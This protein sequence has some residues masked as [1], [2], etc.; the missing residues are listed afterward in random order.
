MQP[1]DDME[2]PVIEELIQRVTKLEVQL[3]TFNKQFISKVQQVIS[4]HTHLMSGEVHWQLPEEM[5]KKQVENLKE[6]LEEIKKK[7]V[8][9]K[10][11]KMSSPTDSFGFEL[12]EVKLNEV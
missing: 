4:W 8:V 2:E 5:I 7:K 9:N 6:R 10:K 12:K 11:E 3:E 1:S